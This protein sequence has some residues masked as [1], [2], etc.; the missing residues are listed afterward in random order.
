MAVQTREVCFSCSSSD[1]SFLCSGVSSIKLDLDSAA[2]YFCS[3][4]DRSGGRIDLED[5][6][7][8]EKFKVGKHKAKHFAMVNGK[9]HFV[10]HL[11]SCPDC[12]KA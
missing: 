2:C 5:G 3:V 11:S 12:L 1:V 4:N 8:T 9:C 7:I 10:V 6:N